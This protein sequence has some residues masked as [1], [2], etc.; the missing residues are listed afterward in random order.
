[1]KTANGNA[2]TEEILTCHLPTPAAGTAGPYLHPTIHTIISILCEFVIT[3]I[4]EFKY[5]YN[6]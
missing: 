1:M 3:N 4:V 2:K 5:G 6:S